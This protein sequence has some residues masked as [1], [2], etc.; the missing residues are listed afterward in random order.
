MSIDYHYFSLPIQ[1]LNIQG[2]VFDGDPEYLGSL[3]VEIERAKRFFISSQQYIVNLVETRCG[4]L[5]IREKRSQFFEFELY[6]KNPRLWLKTILDPET[7]KKYIFLDGTK[8][9]YHIPFVISTL[10]TQKQVYD[11]IFQSILDYLSSLIILNT[12]Y[13]AQEQNDRLDVLFCALQNLLYSQQFIG[14]FF[15]KFLIDLVTNRKPKKN[16]KDKPRRTLLRVVSLKALQKKSG[17]RGAHTKEERKLAIR[18]YENETNTRNDIR[19]FIPVFIWDILSPFFDEIDVLENEQY[20][21]PVVFLQ[22][23]L[24][25][26]IED[27]FNAHEKEFTEGGKRKRQFNNFSD[28]CHLWPDLINTYKEIKK[29]NLW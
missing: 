27:F 26:K 6:K 11:Y 21:N 5:S 15:E 2:R 3:K 9:C 18:K 29:A 24:Y 25:N 19:A 20:M 17:G 13:N 22:E 10:K 16:K 7:T 12:L 8:N 23:K 14:S 1:G 28:F 4:D